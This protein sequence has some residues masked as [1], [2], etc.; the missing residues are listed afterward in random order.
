[1]LSIH[2]IRRELPNMTD[3]ASSSEIE[4]LRRELL[5]RR[6]KSSNAGAASSAPAGVTPRDRARPAPLSQ[7]QLRLWFLSRL[8]V[9]ASVAY[10]MS[11]AVELAGRLH[12]TALCAALDRIVA[13]HEILRTTFTEVSGQ[14]V[15]Q[16]HAPSIGFLLRIEDL[17]GLDHQTQDLA[18]AKLA[19]KE[20]AT[21]FD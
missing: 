16:V 19:A 11:L 2:V 10:H 17:T 6:L 18:I 5:L 3:T 12:L 1:M 4:A 13:R 14:A 15:Q 21:A 9:S 20:V 8:D 7:P